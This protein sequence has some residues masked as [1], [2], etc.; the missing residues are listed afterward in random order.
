MGLNSLV[1]FGNGHCHKML[2]VS[3]GTFNVMVYA[4]VPKYHDF[5]LN[6]N[7]RIII[8]FLNS[9]PYVLGYDLY[10]FKSRY[11]IRFIVNLQ[12]KGNT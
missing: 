3:T 7:Y 4:Y 10:I 12:K 2:R 5:Q 8:S 6:T 11:D 9:Y 1:C